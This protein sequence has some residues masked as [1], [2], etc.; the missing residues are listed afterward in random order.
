MTPTVM[1]VTP[2][3][4]WQIPAG[5]SGALLLVVAGGFVPLPAAV[6][7]AALGGA[8]VAAAILPA[9]VPAGSARSTEDSSTSH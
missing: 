4:R 7:L 5:V 3:L 6:S 8:L 2:S 1:T 9:V